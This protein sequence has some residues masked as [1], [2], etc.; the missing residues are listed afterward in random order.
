MNGNAEFMRRMKGG[1]RRKKEGGMKGVREG[2]KK[3]TEH[4]TLEA[5]APRVWWLTRLDRVLC[6]K[7]W[8]R[9]PGT[10]T[11]KV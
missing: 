7:S 9:C 4:T 11:V 10:R 2:E 5:R 3:K 8:A 1:M 6:S